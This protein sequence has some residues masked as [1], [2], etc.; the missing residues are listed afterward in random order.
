MI[1]Q[2]DHHSGVPI[3]RQVIDQ[4]R[5][6]IMT[7]VISTG[8][9]LDSVRELAGRLNVN[10]M[11]ISKA[12]SLLEAEGLVDRRRGVGVFVADVKVAKQKQL[13]ADILKKA[14]EKAAITAIQLGVD[15]EQ[16]VEFFNKIYSRHT[17][18]KGRRK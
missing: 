4:I 11:T 10:P 9:R 7:E 2:I 16:A 15:Q 8:E 17:D 5:R 12:Y 13:K 6:H 14:V 18:T 3:Y 1:L